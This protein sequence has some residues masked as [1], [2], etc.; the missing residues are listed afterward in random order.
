M[1]ILFLYFI[2]VIPWTNQLN[3]ISFRSQRRRYFEQYV[4]KF[5]MA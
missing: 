2:F 4:L 3:N 1:L 5:W